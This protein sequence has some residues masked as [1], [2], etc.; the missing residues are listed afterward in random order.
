MGLDGKIWWGIL[1]QLKMLGCSCDW[2]RTKFTLDDE[3]YESVLTAF[4]ILHDK[5]LIYRDTE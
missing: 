2:D 3:M 5:G 1:E 4:K